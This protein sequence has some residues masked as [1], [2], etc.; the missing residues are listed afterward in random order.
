MHDIRCRMQEK[1]NMPL[2]KKLDT[3]CKSTRGLRTEG[4]REDVK[5]E[6]N[7][8]RGARCEVSGA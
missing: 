6:D 7:K 5:E 4:K 8:R 1:Q 3:W 2:A